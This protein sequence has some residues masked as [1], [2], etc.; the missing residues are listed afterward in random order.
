MDIFLSEDVQKILAGKTIL[1]QGDSLVRGLYKDLVWL[2]NA[3]SIINY[4]VLGSKGEYRYPELDCIDNKVLKKTFENNQDYLK[5]LKVGEE[6]ES[7]D[8]FKG[9]SSGRTYRE[10]REYY[11]EKFD[12]YII[13]KFTTQVDTFNKKEING[14]PIDLILVNS[15]LWDFNRWGPLGHEDLTRNFDSFIS[16][17]PNCSQTFWITFPPISD[18]TASKGMT[19]E[20]LEFQNFLSKSHTVEMNHYT[21]SK[22]LQRSINCIDLHYSLM[23]QVAHRN[24]DGIHWSPTAN[25]LMTNKIL[26]HITLALNGPESLPGR[27]KKS[28]ALER[29]INNKLYGADK[30]ARRTFEKRL[31]NNMPIRT[32]YFENDFTKKV[33]QRVYFRRQKIAENSKKWYYRKKMYLHIILHG[34]R[35]A[36]NV[37]M[38]RGNSLPPTFMWPAHHLASSAPQTFPGPAY[39]EMASTTQVQG[40]A[41]SYTNRKSPTNNQQNAQMSLG[42]SIKQKL[43]NLRTLNKQKSSGSVFKSK[44]GD[45]LPP[46]FPWSAH[47]MDSGPQTY[48]EPAYQEMASANKLQASGATQRALFRAEK[49]PGSLD[50]PKARGKHK[51]G[52]HYEKVTKKK[53][54]LEE[55]ENC[56]EAKEHW[57]EDY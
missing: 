28:T 21:A 43:R 45:S 55:E 15:S 8:D 34:G 48:P 22:M 26:T 53:S 42:S 16:S 52:D 19:T 38:H 50:K 35:V 51:L 36:S 2:L 9:V 54:K 4:K 13:F 37:Q 39:Q 56:Y 47:H 57:Y 1:F 32:D 5:H 41:I 14:R 17:L 10:Y 49:S 44:R 31:E 27:N 33:E 24:R 18:E 3:N 6:T 7:Q 40:P 12:I 23:G 46:T 30:K 25:R 20:G 11:N 29:I